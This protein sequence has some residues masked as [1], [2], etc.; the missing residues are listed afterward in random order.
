[1]SS[2]S[3]PRFVLRAQDVLAPQCIAFYAELLRR[4]GDHEQAI[5]VETRGIEFLRWQA[6][7]RERVKMPD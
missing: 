5:E 2:D 6:R 4:H 1:M 3:E 7:N